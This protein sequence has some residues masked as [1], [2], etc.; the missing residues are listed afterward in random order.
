MARPLYDSEYIFGIHEPGG[1]QE[2][3]NA[4][5]PG[6]IVFTEGIG[7]DPQDQSGRDYRTFSE[8]GLGVICRL[9]NGYHP[10]G[11]IPYRHS[12]ADF[13]RRCANF[14]A[15]SRGCKIWIIG[16]E[17][18][19][20]IERPQSGRAM[21]PGHDADTEDA[22]TPTPTPD[23]GIDEV[24]ISLDESE[25]GGGLLG[26]LRRLFGGTS[27]APSDGATVQD[28]ARPT[29]PRPPSSDVGPTLAPPSHRTAP[30]DDPFFHGD[31][32]RFNALT[33]P[34]AA[35]AGP[36][37]EDEELRPSAL[38]RGVI[39]ETITPE[40]YAE[41]YRLC[42]AAIH[43]VPGHEDDQVLIGAVAPWNNQTQY[44]GNPNGDWVQ[45]FHD[46][47]LLLGQ[48]GCDGI[49]LHTYT[50]Q[51]DPNLIRSDA[52]M[53]APFQDRHYEF[54]AYQD[55]MYA[56]PVT[57]R[58]LP[59]YITETD[60]DVAWLDANIGWVQQAYGEIDWWNRQPGNQQI[61]ALILYRWPRIDKWYIEG[62]GGV[63]ADFRQALLH[64]YRW[65]IEMPPP[66]DFEAGD[67]VETLDVVNLR[68]TP[69]YIGQPA[70][71]VITELPTGTVLTVLAT[72]YA[73]ADGLVWWNVRVAADTVGVGGW[74]AQITPNGLPLLRKS[75]G[76]QP[77]DGGEIRV[78]GRVRT[79][80]SARMRQ[81]PGYQDKPANDVIVE[82]TP[83]VEG[84]VI[85]GPEARDGLTWW[86]LSV[87]SLPRAVRMGWVAEV[88]PNG[89]L[90]LEAM[91]AV[92]PPS[93]GNNGGGA[94][95][96]FRPGDQLVTKDF[97]NL[98]RTPGYRDKPADDVAA[99][100][101]PDTAATVTSGPV[102][103]DELNWWRLATVTPEGLPVDGWAADTAPNGVVLL[104]FPAAQPP[105]LPADFFRA[106]EL[107]QTT[108]WVRVRRSPGL[109]GKPD[110][111]TIGDFVPEITLLVLDGPRE[112]DGLSWWQVSGISLAVGELIGWVAQSAPSGM[113]LLQRAPDLPGTDIPSKR[114][115]G[116]PFRGHY[117][118]SQ[119]WA[120][121]PEIYRRFSYDGVALMGHNGVDFL[122]PT[123]V[124]LLAV[125]DGIVSDAV[126]NDPTGFGH[127]VKV[128]HS[129]GE[130]VY[131]HM[132]TIRVSQ[133][134]QV[135]R[136][137][138]LGTS[139]DTGFSGGPH[140]HFAI[141]INPYDRTDGWGGFSDPLPYLNPND[142][143][144]PAY[145]FPP[146]P[147]APAFDVGP[148]MSR[149][150]GPGMAP[151]QPGVPRP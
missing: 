18:N 32:S 13:A 127:Y 94:T 136:G 150:T 15:N 146:A 108:T 107:I 91:P 58:H 97:V 105:I 72:A 65:G 57:M 99:E 25:T 22:P 46:I 62:K 11:T 7:H 112:A 113:V 102:V 37:L 85:A 89:V 101:T 121:H 61:R 66:A 109:N 76:V 71:D 63:I 35:D 59:V 53:N 134:E 50:H 67:M 9:N 1:E 56:I 104:D 60:Q 93:L 54:R 12:Y 24:T 100:L 114:Y 120:E 86:R 139:D 95:G 64:D 141:R 98:R 135:R 21:G 38:V 33:I 84:D 29:P 151:D 148:A 110:D 23:D 144:L 48:D 14:V 80:Q 8:R 125:D 39:E 43:A 118:I 36:V 42:R 28:A 19:Y 16:N 2:M 78:G 27:G 103:A 133:G 140:L 5:R 79:L 142:Y 149:P 130:S 40:L 116:A 147:G 77:P 70:D 122:T 131:A 128:A 31:P 124:E 143:Y 68:K 126:Y 74:I 138:L 30:T 75:D 73:A 137:Q 44:P 51:A 10:E 81:S 55:F 41:C 145:I 20:A 123:G 17:M 119:L 129:W 34:A 132:Q 115:L 96:K 52:K 49:T 88:A 82:L 4:G 69:G 3:L 117:G 47:L 6:W 26:W 87:P 90:L 83:D 111:D 45:Y 92:R 106:G